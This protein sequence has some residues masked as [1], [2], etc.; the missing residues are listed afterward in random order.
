M[1]LSDRIRPNC[2]AALWVVE[3]VKKLEH[4]NAAL[5]RA[6]VEVCALARVWATVWHD[7]L[8]TE[9]IQWFAELEQRI[10]KERKP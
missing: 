10:L 3:E 6:A 2:E 9:S 5:R 7:K 1:S 8:S 4:E